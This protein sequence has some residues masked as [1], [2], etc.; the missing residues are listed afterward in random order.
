[1]AT[2]FQ[3]GTNQEDDV[4]IAYIFVCDC[5][6][7]KIPTVLA[8]LSTRKPTLFCDVTDFETHLGHRNND[9]IL[10]YHHDLTL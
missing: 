5:P 10:R 8:Y 7:F 3:F 4:M 2:R 6:N 1:M 9:I